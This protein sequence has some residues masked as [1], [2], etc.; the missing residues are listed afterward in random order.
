MNT[1]AIVKLIE[2]AQDSASQETKNA[3]AALMVSVA[4]DLADNAGYSAW[5]RYEFTRPY[6]ETNKLVAGVMWS[7][8]RQVARC[9]TT[10]SPGLAWVFNRPIFLNSKVFHATSASDL[11]MVANEMLDEAE[12][13]AER[14]TKPE[15][16]E[17]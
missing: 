8:D 14:Y 13:L 15:T 2:M 7:E 4:N 11:E 6:S 9:T 17:A 16:D 12:K 3:L 10:L 5:E 1:E